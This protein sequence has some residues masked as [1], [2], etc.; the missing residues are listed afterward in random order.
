MDAAQEIQTP[1]QMS[2]ERFDATDGLMVQSLVA[3]YFQ[4]TDRPGPELVASLFAED[5]LLV[6]GPLKLEGR[7]AIAAF[8]AERNRSQAEVGRLTRH[9]PGLLE[10]QGVSPDRIKGR[11]T[12]VVYAGTGAVPLPAGS[13][14]TICDFDDVYVR[15]ADGVWRFERRTAAVIF[16]G[17]GAAGFAR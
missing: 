3:A 5:G 6:L 7:S 16:T 13:P 8:F 9:L 17:A 14:S 12:V 1:P 4:R 10:L 2:R 15:Q 11:S